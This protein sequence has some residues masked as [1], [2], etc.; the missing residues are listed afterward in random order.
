MMIRIS[1]LFTSTLFF[2]NLLHVSPFMV[3]KQTSKPFV[4][5]T[6]T[7]SATVRS[8]DGLVGFV[9]SHLSSR[10]SS[11]SA[12]NPLHMKLD[13]S[14]NDTIE[15][16]KKTFMNATPKITQVRGLEEFLDLVAELDDRI[17]VIEFYAAWCKSCHKFG[18][19]F[20]H[21]ANTYADKVDENGD[22]LERGKVRFA[23]VEYGANVRLCKSFG[24]KKL[25]YVQM[26]KAPIG[27]LSEFV[28]GPKFF[29][30][31]LKNRLEDYLIKSDEEIAFDRD[32]EDGQALSANLL[33]KTQESKTKVNST[34]Y[35]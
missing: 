15:T 30:E 10:P 27:K 16:S 31:R 35:N 6:T 7:K 4:I 18:A 11:S 13:E 32:M 9:F 33:D 34:S 20:R 23:M 12:Y 28:C 2:L 17:L 25:P 24:I 5:G 22:V 21:L 14:D 3:H 29:D 19:K 8:H 1:N 26:Y